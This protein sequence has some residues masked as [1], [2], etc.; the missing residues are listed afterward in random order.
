[1]DLRNFARKHVALKAEVIAEGASYVGIVKNFSEQGL[2][3]ETVPMHNVVEFV[4]EKKLLVKF[5]LPSGEKLTLDCEVVWLYSKKISSSGL[6]QNIVGMKLVFP[7]RKLSR[8][9][10]ENP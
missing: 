5:E 3:L 8:Y 7:S 10:K 2:F 4:P 1:M 6:K 9:L